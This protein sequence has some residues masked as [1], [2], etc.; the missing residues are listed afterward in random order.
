MVRNDRQVRDIMVDTQGEILE[1]LGDPIETLSKLVCLL[2]KT[3]QNPGL[4]KAIR[5]LILDYYTIY[6]ILGYKILLDEKK[7]KGLP[8]PILVVYPSN[9][10]VRI[11]Y[12]DDHLQIYCSEE[13]LYTC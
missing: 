9:C 12:R 10:T 3:K 8:E 2:R 4:R 1:E 5:N 6:R 13:L 7:I 11:L